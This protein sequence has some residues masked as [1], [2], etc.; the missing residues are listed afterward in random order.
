ML[1][2]DDPLAKILV[3][4]EGFR[5]CVYKDSLG[6]W[7]IG[8]GT[9]VDSRKPGAGISRAAGL[10]LMGEAVEEKEE[11]LD[12]YIPWWRTLD[13]VRQTIIQAMSYQMGVGVPGGDEGLLG[14]RNTL[15]AIRDGMWR[16]AGDGMRESLWYQQTPERAERMAKMMESGNLL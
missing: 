12:E 2:P 4:E 8:Y 13:P 14:F 15:R 9:L 16:T 5:S 1:S 11:Q 10:F 6:Y 7:T 3:F